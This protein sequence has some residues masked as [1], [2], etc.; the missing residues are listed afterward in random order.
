MREDV[1]RIKR[2][3]L[4]LFL[5]REI[6]D[7]GKNAPPADLARV[8]LAARYL[9]KPE[10]VQEVFSDD[11]GA[12]IPLRKKVG[13]PGADSR[14]A[15]SKVDKKKQN[16]KTHMF[17]DQ[18]PK[19]PT[20]KARKSHS[21]ATLKQS[22]SNQSVDDRGLDNL[23][24]F[25]ADPGNKT[26][27]GGED[28]LLEELLSSRKDLL[29]HLLEREIREPDPEATQLETLHRYLGRSRDPLTMSGTLLPGQS[30]SSKS[31]QTTPAVT[32]MSQSMG[33]FKM[34]NSFGSTVPEGKREPAEP[35][36]SAWFTKKR[37]WN[38]KFGAKFGAPNTK[39]SRQA[40]DQ[41]G[42]CIAIGD[43]RLP[44]HK[45]SHLACHGYFWQFVV[46]EVADELFPAELTKDMSIGFGVSKVSPESQSSRGMYA[47]E[48]S[49]AILIGYG[50]HLIDRGHWIRVPWDPIGL[51]VGEAVGML[52]TEE[53]DLVVFVNGSQ[54]LRVATSLEDDEDAGHRR[55]LFPI[56]DLCGRISSVTMLPQAAPPNVPLLVRTK[57]KD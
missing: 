19:T 49:D 53:G 46:D 17:G 48:K 37:A 54:V 26:R 21:P 20:P 32:S 36:M 10:H 14:N 4:R 3:L 41:A 30:I 43:G 13:S 57:L 5:E 28:A 56:I 52:V 55:S 35:L 47:Y 27:G 42:G 8:R 33:D 2:Q 25:L 1:L 22:Q 34:E 29:R 7:I 6:R 38:A 50:A 11:D 31:R 24:D 40:I 45:Q 51:R 15:A 39:V 44:L 18:S 16:R 9:E 23:I 12:D